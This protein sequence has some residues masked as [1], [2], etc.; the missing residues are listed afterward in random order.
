MTKSI[1]IEILIVTTLLL[2]VKIAIATPSLK[3]ATVYQQSASHNS[4]K[5]RTT[6]KYKKTAKIKD[7]NPLPPL[8][9]PSI[10]AKAFQQQQYL[11]AEASSQQTPIITDN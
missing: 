11:K 1:I 7:T 2:A 10:R 6:A 4:I 5:I 3:T 8:N 9:R